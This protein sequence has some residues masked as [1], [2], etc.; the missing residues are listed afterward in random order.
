MMAVD[1]AGTNAFI[2]TASGL[3]I[4]PLTPVSSQNAPALTGSAVVNT[5]SFTAGVAPGGLISIFG[6][7][8]GTTASAVNVPLPVVLGGACVT[9]NNSPLPLLATTAGQVNAQL[10]PTLAA[11][12]YPLVVRSTNAQ[13]ASGSVTVTVAKYAPA[14][15]V[16]SQGPAIFHKDGARVDKSHPASRDEPLTIFATGLGTTTG[17]KVTAGNV[18]PSSPLAVTAPV[19]LFFG[20]P[21]IKQTAVIVDWSGLLPGSIGVYQINARIPGFHQKGD[22]MPVTLRIGGVSSPTTGPTAALVYVN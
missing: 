22:A 9:L 3:S 8:L 17:G 15:F 2:L 1:A 5:A 18:S 4:I 7:N 13:A 19:T 20:D 16:D 10:P 12:R 21:T 6:R 11:G 14:I